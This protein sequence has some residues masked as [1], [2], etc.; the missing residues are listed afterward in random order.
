MK[1][2]PECYICSLQQVLSAARRVTGEPETERKLLKK[3]MA[4]LLDLDPEFTPAEIA[5]DLFRLACQEL[6]VHDPYRKEMDHFNRQALEL[7]PRLQQ[8]LAKSED[9][10]YTALLLAVAGNQIDLGIIKEIDVEGTI[11]QVLAEGL[12]HN[13]YEDFRKDLANADS[14]LYLVDNAGEIV[15]DRILLEEIKKAYPEL[16]VTVAVKKEPAANDA[17]RVDALQTGMDR[18]GAIIDTGCGD[19]GVPRRRCSEEFEEAFR[20]AGLVIAKGHANFETIEGD[21]KHP[22]AY[23]LLRAKCPVV[24]G[25]LGV[26]VFASVFKKLS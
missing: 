1:A 26:E 4:Y 18:V 25:I 19:L 17:L 16:R 9:R 14:L 11:A 23:A 22:A 10:I 2:K 12:R 3:A 7:Y 15:F 21:R 20:R 13:D 6:N 8:V 5:S 24:A